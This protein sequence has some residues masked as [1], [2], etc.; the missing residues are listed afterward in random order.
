MN[1]A[2]EQIQMLV[3]EGRLAEAR[4]L[5][6]Q[7]CQQDPHNPRAWFEMGTLLAQNGEL[8]EAA[9]CFHRVLDLKPEDAETNFNL[10]NIYK[11]GSRLDTAIGHYREALR[12]RPDFPEACFNLANTLREKGDID[13][14][15]K[16]YDKAIELHP[17]Y[18]KA[19]IALS[20]AFKA[21]KSHQDAVRTIKRAISQNPGIAMLHYLLGNLFYEN[22]QPEHAAEQYRLAIQYSPDF[23]FAHN[24]LG[25]ALRLQGDLPSAIASFKRALTLMPDNVLPY[26]NLGNAQ[27][28]SGDLASA[29]Q[30][31][32]SALNIQ[33]GQPEVYFALSQVKHFSPLDQEIKD[34][35]ALL[36]HSDLSVDQRLMVH[37]ALGKA[38]EDA[39]NYEQSF[40][41]LEAGNRL[42]RSTFHYSVEEDKALFGAISQVFDSTL[43]E[44]KSG[45]GISD[46]SPI[47]ILG[48]PRSGTSLVEQIL[49]SHPQVYGAG[50]LHDL[51]ISILDSVPQYPPGSF[52]FMAAK[53][54]RNDIATIASAYLERTS[55]YYRH[56]D[57]VTDKMPDNFIYIGM[58]RLMFPN[59]RII[60][61]QRD[62]VDTCLSCYK[63]WFSDSQP[64]AYDLVEL[65]QYYL[66]YRDLMDHWHRVLPDFIYDIQ[67]EKLVENQEQETRRL[68]EYC[69]LS[70][71]NKCISFHETDRPVRTASSTQVRQPLY[72]DSVR[73]WKSFENHL[74]PLLGILGQP[75]SNQQ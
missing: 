45:F 68:L 65:G 31:F 17:G 14:A 16:L 40:F 6:Q 8:Q 11:S 30:T 61:C 27:Q 47:F 34:M 12:I 7:L 48:M 54:N 53:L 22:R 57:F 21:R 9:G 28:Q 46:A 18:I 60:H 38:Y 32:Q 55:R 33:T 36:G 58:I 69:E 67:Y 49:S 41:H 72:N 3:N 51:R 35:E 56:A 37:F 75:Y 42:K 25:N 24:N 43:F 62:P 39:G 50:E 29:L 1:H 74:D 10:G 2:F 64:F 15:I 59:A 70:W 52:P 13:S 26:I 44:E 23:A 19:H 73:R 4:A 20:E 5:C 63:R 66:G 71:D